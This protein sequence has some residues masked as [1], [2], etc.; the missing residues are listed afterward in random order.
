MDLNELVDDVPTLVPASAVTLQFKK[1]ARKTS[2]M[3]DKMT[4]TVMRILLSP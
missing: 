1:K 3:E 4:R 2:M